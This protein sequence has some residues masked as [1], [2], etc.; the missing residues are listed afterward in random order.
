MLN[1]HTATS[2]LITGT[3][4]YTRNS[5]TQFL[6]CTLST[7]SKHSSGLPPPNGSLRVW[8]RTFPTAASSWEDFYRNLELDFLCNLYSC[9]IFRN[10]IDSAASC[11]YLFKQGRRWCV[12]VGVSVRVV[13]KQL[14][15]ENDPTPHLLLLHLY[16]SAHA[17]SLPSVPLYSLFNSVSGLSKGLEWI[18]KSWLHWMSN[19]IGN[20]KSHTH[21]TL[22]DK[23]TYTNA[24]NCWNRKN[25][26]IF[27]RSS[28]E[29]ELLPLYL[30]IYSI[31]S[32]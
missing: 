2:T 31:W 32:A 4:I 8:K 20:I 23:G 11:L 22:T 30:V 9:V 1:D 24:T 25:K 7:H 10:P 27:C 21:K 16:P 26:A 14:E 28:G 13:M 3:H 29:K 19:H 15:R 6:F 12:H 18:L 17:C 5:Y